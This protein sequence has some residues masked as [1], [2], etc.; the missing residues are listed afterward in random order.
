MNYIN[1]FYLSSND[2]GEIIDYYRMK[3][4]EEPFDIGFD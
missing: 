2:V 3:V 4:N 1:I